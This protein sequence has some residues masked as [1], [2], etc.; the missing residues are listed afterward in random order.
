MLVDNLILNIY[1]DHRLTI[2]LHHSV[3]P[4]QMER[5]RK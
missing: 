3:E 2:D 1:L 4:L 5:G